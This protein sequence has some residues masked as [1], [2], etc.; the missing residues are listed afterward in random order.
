MTMSGTKAGP[1]TGPAQWRSRLI[2]VHQRVTTGEDVSWH[3]VH[4]SICESAPCAQD[5]LSYHETEP[6]ISR[7]QH[8]RHPRRSV[9]R[10][11]NVERVAQFLGHS[12]SPRAG[13]DLVNN[14]RALKQVTKR[15]TAASG[16]QLALS[17][18]F[19]ARRSP[20]KGK[21]LLVEAGFDKKFAC[22]VHNLHSLISSIRNPAL[23]KAQSWPNNTR[24]IQWI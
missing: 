22:R 23:K 4:L 11:V 2:E 10:T 18:A 16:P 5:R 9:G 21:T 14:R 15:E 12:N 8:R 6:L 13:F 24:I 20:Q 3:R 19:P 17:R 1:A 7:P